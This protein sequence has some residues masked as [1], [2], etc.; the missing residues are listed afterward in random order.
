MNRF[1]RKELKIIKSLR[2][3]RFIHFSAW[4][5]KRFEDP[6]FK[7]MFPEFASD[8]YW[9]MQIT[10]LRDQLKHIQKEI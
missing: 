1:D 7:R 10:D 8:N 3:L 4:I 9:E 2:A 6:A 5:A